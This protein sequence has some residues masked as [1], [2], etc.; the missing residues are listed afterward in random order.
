[1]RAPRTVVERLVVVAKVVSIKSEGIGVTVI[2]EEEREG[3]E[4][5]SCIVSGERAWVSIVWVKGVNFTEIS[6]SVRSR[7]CCWN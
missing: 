1:M 4:V 3:N 2:D 6:L 5:V 7:R